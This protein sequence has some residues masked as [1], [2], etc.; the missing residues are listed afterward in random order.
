MCN[1]KFCTLTYLSIE[2]PNLKSTSDVDA[3]KPT[4]S[5]L[6]LGRTGESILP[7]EMCFGNFFFGGGTERFTPKCFSN[8]SVYLIYIYLM[9]RKNFIGNIDFKIVT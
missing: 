9:L 5:V 8:F 3:G 1:L 2:N 7:Q 4:L 6:K